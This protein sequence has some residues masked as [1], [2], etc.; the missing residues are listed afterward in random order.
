[1]IALYSA[2]IERPEYSTFTFS[3][4]YCLFVTSYPYDRVK[5]SFTA[6]IRSRDMLIPV[7]S[8]QVTAERSSSIASLTPRYKRL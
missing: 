7:L 1:M 4:I 6:S 8:R 2:A 3:L 5:L